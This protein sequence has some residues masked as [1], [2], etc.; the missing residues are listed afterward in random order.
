MLPTRFVDSLATGPILGAIALAT[1]TA[2]TELLDPLTKTGGALGCLGFLAW[3]QVAKD[4]H[5]AEQAEKREAI[6]EERFKAMQAARD[7]T[8]Q[9][10]RELMREQAN[11]SQAVA[12]SIQ[13]LAD[14]ITDQLGRLDQL[15]ETIA[16]VG[17]Q[18]ARRTQGEK[19]T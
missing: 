17:R 4:K 2:P 18:Q 8:D 1:Y 11:S 10:V 12:I 6:W 5:A 19:R 9:Q 16:N 7:A 15:T 14:K 3:Q 13:K